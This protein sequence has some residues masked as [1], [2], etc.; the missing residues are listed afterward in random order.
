[1]VEVFWTELI[2]NMQNVWQIHSVDVYGE[3]TST[4]SGW[5]ALSCLW[6]CE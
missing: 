4:G 1:M 2:L 6:Y 3:H 5:N